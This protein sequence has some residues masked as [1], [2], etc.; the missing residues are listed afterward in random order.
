MKT[1]SNGNSLLLRRISLRPDNPVN[2][3]ILSK[4]GTRGFTLVELLVALSI[5]SILMTA[6]VIIFVGALRTTQ[7]GYQQMDAFERGRSALTVIENDLVRSYTSHQSADLH[8]FYGTPIGMTFVGTT[9][10]TSKA[11][12]VNLAR[13]TYV[14]YNPFRHLSQYASCYQS[15]SVPSSGQM[16]D[17]GDAWEYPPYVYPVLRYV[18][19]NVGDLES[20]PFNLNG[21][22][23]EGN[24]TYGN[25]LRDLC[26]YA[27]KDLDFDYTSPDLT[28]R[29]EATVRAKKCEMWIRMLAGGDEW[30]PSDLPSG[31]DVSLPVDFW[32]DILGGG[33][34]SN[35][36]DDCPDPLYF[37]YVITGNVVSFVPP[38]QRY[39]APFD[40]DPHEGDTCEKHYFFSYR[41]TPR[42]TDTSLAVT[43]YCDNPDEMPPRRCFW[44]P[45]SRLPEVVQ[46]TLR[47]GFPSPYP[48]APDFQ[49][50]FSLE[51]NLPTGYTRAPEL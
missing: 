31:L 33:C 2:P 1:P 44:W 51:V 45:I 24:R 40:V 47:L 7:T 35:P 12:D 4:K 38:D 17:Y 21:T 5:F 20:F 41:C 37:D 26:R 3:V 49:R 16:L 19:P 14:V 29:E 39:A 48:G 27:L 6:L 46:V 50:L 25:V 8:K 11:D 36:S 10:M 22:L 30:R 43:D 9:Q 13:I 42:T 23:P 28:P 15:C 34:P 32:W 18:Q